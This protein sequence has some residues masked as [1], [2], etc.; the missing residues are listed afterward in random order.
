[1]IF[2]FFFFWGGSVSLCLYKNNTAFYNAVNTWRWWVSLFVE[3]QAACFA[4]VVVVVCLFWGV[5]F[6][7]DEF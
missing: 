4:V 1:M 5:V 6:F 3:V 2:F 7:F